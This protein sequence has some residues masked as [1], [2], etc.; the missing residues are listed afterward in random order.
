MNELVDTGKFAGNYNSIWVDQDSNIYISYS[1]ISKLKLAK[2]IRG[3]W[4]LEVVDP[5]GTV[6]YTSLSIDSDGMAH[7][8]Y[9]DKERGVKYARQRRE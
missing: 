2:N 8:A 5:V 4:S 9:Y 1:A 6:T 7:I 3:R